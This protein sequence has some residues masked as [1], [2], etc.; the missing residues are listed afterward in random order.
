MHFLNDSYL[1][2]GMKKHQ[3]KYIDTSDFILFMG[4]YEGLDA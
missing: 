2:K 3:F 4:L 1:I